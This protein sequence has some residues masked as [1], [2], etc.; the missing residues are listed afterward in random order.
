MARTHRVCALGQ[1]GSL[2]AKTL[3]WLFWLWVV[4]LVVDEI[5]QALT[6]RHVDG[7]S[8]LQ[9]Y[10]RGSGNGYDLL[11]NCGFFVAASCRLLAQIISS[12]AGLPGD[13]LCQKTVACELYSVMMATLAC[14]FIVG[15]FRLLYMFSVHKHIGVLMITIRDIVLTDIRPWMAVLIVTMVSFEVASRYFSW[16][17]EIDTYESGMY[18]SNLSLLVT[19]T[20]SSSLT[21]SL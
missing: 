20:T 9:A 16:S 21:D 14:C 5:V 10:I 1:E 19:P 7:V 2:S 12:S 13:D 11:I 17:L 15:C 8:A 6:A 18:T 3:E 4:T